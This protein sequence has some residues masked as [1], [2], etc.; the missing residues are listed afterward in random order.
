MP[1]ITTSTLNVDLTRIDN[2][3]VRRA[4]RQFVQQV[5]ETINEQQV[6]IEALLDLMLDKHVAS[7][8]EF[9]RHVQL[10]RLR[11]NER[12]ERLHTQV[13]QAM[14]E[15]KS[16]LQVTPR[17]VEVPEESGRHVYKLES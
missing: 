1:Q 14:R 5:Q 12:T 6:E 10:I 15:G 7:L 4:L 16:S 2:A 17:E 13:A 3:E 9:K 8:G 11:S